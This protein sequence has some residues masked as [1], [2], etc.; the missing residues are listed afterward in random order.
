MTVEIRDVGSG[1][2]EV[3]ASGRH[4]EAFLDVERARAVATDLAMKI[5][6]EGGV[7]AFVIEVPGDQGHSGTDGGSFDQ[8]TAA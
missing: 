7:A 2:F 8:R 3:F 1:R 6:K 4:W 5:G